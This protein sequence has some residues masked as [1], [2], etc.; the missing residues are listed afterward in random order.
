MEQSYVSIITPN[1]NV[2]S[3]TC[4]E[5]YAECPDQSQFISFI[6]PE[7]PDGVNYIVYDNITNQPL[8]KLELNRSELFKRRINSKSDNSGEY[9]QYGKS[10]G[11]LENGVYTTN[12]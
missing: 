9:G 7:S 6:S 10:S 2:E 5:H 8:G 11:Q 1:E 12:K 3:S 4:E